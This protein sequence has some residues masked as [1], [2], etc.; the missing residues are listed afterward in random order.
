MSKALSMLSG[1]SQ[2]ITSREHRILHFRI[3][4]IAFS[5]GFS[6]VSARSAL[7]GRRVMLYVLYLSLVQK[8]LLQ[9]VI[10]KQKV[11]RITCVPY[12]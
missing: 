1:N 5:L 6:P 12:F 2:V 9:S 11:V 10:I 7:P 4:M 3:M 8:L